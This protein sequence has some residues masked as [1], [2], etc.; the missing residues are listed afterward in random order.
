MQLCLPCPMGKPSLQ[1]QLLVLVQVQG[2][3]QGQREQGWQQLA[4]LGP[5]LLLVPSSQSC[6]AADCPSRQ[7]Q[8]SSVA[9]AACLKALVWKLLLL[10][11]DQQQKRM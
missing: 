4:M 2:Q 6:P 5:R 7:L 9:P 8:P 11:P 1:R 3:G 10:R